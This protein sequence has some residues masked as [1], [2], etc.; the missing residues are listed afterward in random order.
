MAITVIE[1]YILHQSS[2]PLFGIT[3]NAGHARHAF[4]VCAPPILR[5]DDKVPVNS[6]SVKTHA[7][8]T[9]TTLVIAHQCPHK[10]ESTRWL[11]LTTRPTTLRPSVCQFS[12]QRV[13]KTSSYRMDS[14]IQRQVS[15]CFV[16][17]CGKPSCC[18]TSGCFLFAP[19]SAR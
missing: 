12:R 10:G 9:V 16:Q 8:F 18:E 2:S 13:I 4:V 5:I 6:Y 17:K 15:L 14:Q 1:E 11:T 3:G 19:L 7:V